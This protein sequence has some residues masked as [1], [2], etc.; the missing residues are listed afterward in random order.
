MNQLIKTG[1]LT[2]L[3]IIIFG[4][5]KSTEETRYKCL[6]QMTNYTGEG[7]YV[8][9]SLLKPDGSYEKTLAVLGK[10]S[11]WYPDLIHWW[12]YQ[13]K[14]QQS[15]DGITGSS[16][17]GGDRTI[18]LLRMDASKLGKGYKLL[19]ESA[20][21]SQVY[22]KKDVAFEFSPA[23]INQKIEGKGYIRYVRIMPG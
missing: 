7:A 3:L 9:V 16:I 6:I 17:T 11:K 2:G 5:T 1:I 14:K 8:T 15:L 12:G 10:E 20:V 21:E 19:F 18:C 13:K 4:F 22:H 23:N